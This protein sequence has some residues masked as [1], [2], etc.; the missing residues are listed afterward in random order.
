MTESTSEFLTRMLRDLSMIRHD[1]AKRG[2]FITLLR[3]IDHAM[4]E[5]EVL[6]DYL[7]ERERGFP[8]VE[9]HE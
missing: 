7:K 8:M 6:S 9:N 5:A 1:V 3:F 2:K 4:I